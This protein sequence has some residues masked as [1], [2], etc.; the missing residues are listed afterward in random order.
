MPTDENLAH[1]WLASK[2]WGGWRVGMVAEGRVCQVH[3]EHPWNGW[4]TGKCEPPDLDHPGTRAF[5]LEDVRRAWG[6]PV[7]VVMPCD[8]RP[9]FAAEIER[10]D[11]WPCYWHRYT[12]NTEAVALIAALEAA[13]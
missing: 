2:H 1:R 12:G 9:E 10:A 13:Q 3:G 4:H 7:A 11:E 6:W 8:R 5:L